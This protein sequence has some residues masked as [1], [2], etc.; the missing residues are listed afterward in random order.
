MQQI[1]AFDPAKL[2][3]RAP[4]DQAILATDLYSSDCASLVGVIRVT[5]TREPHQWER[6]DKG[7][8]LLV[9]LSGSFRMTLRYGHVEEI[10]T[11]N[12]G[13][14]LLIPQGV[15]HSAELDSEH[16]DVLFVSPGEGS[17][18]WSECP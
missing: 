5:N 17:I 14:A 16:I 8:E 2:L 10:Y 6:H 18:E 11:L 13:N 3:E 4:K 7:D 9:L 12:P 15:A 1:Q